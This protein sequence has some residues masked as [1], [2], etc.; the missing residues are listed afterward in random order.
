MFGV[1][2]REE[3]GKEEGGCRDPREGTEVEEGCVG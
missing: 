1:T 3:V 2:W